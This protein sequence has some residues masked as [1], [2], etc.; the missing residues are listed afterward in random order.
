MSGR[1]HL[2]T[3]PAIIAERFGI[4]TVALDLRGWQPRYNIAPTQPT[5]ILRALEG[6]PA[7][8]RGRAAP[9]ALSGVACE[10]AVARWGFIP[11][12]AS[13]PDIGVRTINTRL[14]T[15]DTQP[16]TAEAFSR[17]RCL[18]PVDGFYEWRSSAAGHE[19]PTWIGVRHEE[20]RALG[21][22]FLA[23]VWNR[24]TARAADTAPP[25]FA[26]TDESAIDSFSILTA[27]ANAFMSRIHERMPVIM[28][29]RSLATWLDP[30]N[31]DPG[32]LRELCAGVDSDLFL[33]HPV[34]VHV[35]SPRN[36]GPKCIEP[37]TDADSLAF[38][39]ALA[40]PPR[41]R[42]NPTRPT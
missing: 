8:P 16:L 20:T 28:P 32:M 17:H 19:K 11:E 15:A 4:V 36:E 1:F 23:A 41:A 13:E 26:P 42:R 38:P 2:A 18:I 12:W 25:S 22:F 3:S 7:P 33:A 6:V 34:S 37:T 14:E 27:P 30:Q 10:L 29:E 35:N 9:R 24:W 40:P 31:T 39:I 5:A 21:P